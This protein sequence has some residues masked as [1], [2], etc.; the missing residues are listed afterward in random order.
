MSAGTDGSSNVATT[1]NSVTHELHTIS[2]DTDQSNAPFFFAAMQTFNGGDCATLRMRD[3]GAS[4]VKVHVEEETSRD[5]EIQHT[6]EDVGFMALYDNPFEVPVV[7]YGTGEATLE[8]GSL[9]NLDHNL[10][11][12]NLGQS[13]NNPVVIM[14]TLSYNG[15]D[16]STVRVKDVTANSFAV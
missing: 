14:G 9:T 5:G 10:Q 16:P 11:T 3:L 6:T 4:S 12:V 1:G 7:P 8:M 13:Y 15:G 2:F